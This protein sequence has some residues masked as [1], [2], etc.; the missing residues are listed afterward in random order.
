[1]SAIAT[2]TDR[3]L[4]LMS[5]NHEYGEKPPEVPSTAEPIVYI[6]DDD[7]AV[8]E[9]IVALLETVDVISKTFLSAQEF[10]AVYDRNSEVP[11]CIVLDV[12]MKGMSG[13]ELQ[14]RLR[15]DGLMMPIIMMSGYHDNPTAVRAIKNGA[16]DFL[17]KPIDDQTLI[18][19]VNAAIELDIQR[20]RDEHQVREIAAR[21]AELT[22]REKQ[23]MDV[24]VVG[25]TSKKTGGKLG[26]NYKT[27]EAHR[28]KIMK[29]MEAKTVAHLIYLAHILKLD[30]L[31]NL[32][33]EEVFES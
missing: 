18:D 1:M 24:V 8:C 19:H 11:G 28:A 21:Y 13:I 30:V 25:A 3:V 32:P 6:I 27:V 26:I 14:D 22:D 7:E 15:G 9:S 23:V 10:L 12:R 5:T 33:S 31:K 16:L 17:T 20:R 29:K 2:P 4:G